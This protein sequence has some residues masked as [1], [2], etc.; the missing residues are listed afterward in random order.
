MSIHRML[1][2]LA[3]FALLLVIPATASAD[4]QGRFAMAKLHNAEGEYIGVAIF[5]QLKDDSVQVHVTVRGLTPGLHGVHIHAIGAC[6]PNFGAAGSH[7]NPTGALHPHHAGDLGNIVAGSNGVALLSLTTTSVTLTDGS[8]SL[9]DA[10]G[11]AL[12]IHEGPDDLHTNPTG[13]SGGRVACGVIE[14]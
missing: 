10:D 5:T 11:S 4:S 7:F 13:N 9:H 14:A 3:A 1:L 2:L 12:I 6:S 8:L